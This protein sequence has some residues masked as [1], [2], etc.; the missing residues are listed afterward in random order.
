MPARHQ[1]RRIEATPRSIS[2]RSLLYNR[3]LSIGERM[4]VI[5]YLSTKYK[6]NTQLTLGRHVL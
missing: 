3:D 4:N 6:L 5:G 2:S 1:P